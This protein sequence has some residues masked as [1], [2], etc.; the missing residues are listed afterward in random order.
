MT[1]TIHINFDAKCSQCGD[2]GAADNGLCL[3]CITKNIGKGVRHSM[4]ELKTECGHIEKFKTSTE[5]RDV[6]DDDGG[7]RPSAHHQSLIRGCR[8]SRW[9]ADDSP[10]PR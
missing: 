6:K 3:K 1:D 7:V 2:K 5:I 9:Y 4:P 10:R 8:H